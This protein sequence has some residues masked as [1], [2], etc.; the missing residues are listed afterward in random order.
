MQYSPNAFDRHPHRRPT[1][2]WEMDISLRWFQ[3]R[4][5]S[6]GWEILMLSRWFSDIR[7]GNS[8]PHR[9]AKNGTIKWIS[10]DAVKKYFR[11]FQHDAMF[12]HIF[13]VCTNIWV[14]FSTHRVWIHRRVKSTN[15]PS[16]QPRSQKQRNFNDVSKSSDN[17]CTEKK[18]GCSK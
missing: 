4:R 9:H 16:E 5:T 15:S 10:F 17:F 3:H 1:S 2:S 6:W 14:N 11:D 7:R 12:S 8:S 13:A 18:E